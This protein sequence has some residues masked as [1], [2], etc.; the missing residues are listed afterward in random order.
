MVPERSTGK[1]QEQKLRKMGLVVVE[2]ARAT[3]DGDAPVT[4][5]QIRERVNLNWSVGLAPATLSGYVKQLGV[6]EARKW[7]KTDGQMVSLADEDRTLRDSR[8]IKALFLARRW[9]DR[10]ERFSVRA[11]L[12][13]CWKEFQ[14]TDNTCRPF[15]QDYKQCG[16]LIES[17]DPDRDPDL[18]QLNPRVINEDRFYLNPAGDANL[19]KRTSWRNPDNKGQT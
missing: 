3:N 7:L 5:R 18:E 10:N 12:R 17:D 8:A 2:V 15:L 1:P 19:R 11:W 6:W 9:M 4:Q 16:Y 13:R 14:L